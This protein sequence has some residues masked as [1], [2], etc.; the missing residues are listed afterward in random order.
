MKSM[1]KTTIPKDKCLDNTFKL[2]LE[3]YLFIPNRCR[4]YRSDLFQTRMM[5]Q[6]VICMS[7]ESAAKLFY[8]KIR[9]TRKGA[10]PKRIQKTLFGVKAIQTLVGADHKNR[11]SLFVSFMTPS[12]IDHLV[13]IMRKEWQLSSRRWMEKERIV[14]FDEACAMLCR[15][16][17][18]WSG[19][20]LKKSEV[21]QRAMDLS[22]MI[23]AF[24][25]VGPRYWKGKCARKRTEMWMKNMIREVRRGRLTP[26][27]DSI[28]QKIAFHKDRHGKLLEANIAGIEMINILRPITAIATYITFGA[29][30]MEFHPECRV[31]IKEREGNYLHML[32][33]EIRRY[34]PFGPFLGARVRSDFIY[35]NFRFKKG[36]LT[37]LDIYG[38]NH[39][40]RIW[41]KPYRFL[42]EHF[43]FKDGN[44]YD[45]IPQGGGDMETGTRCPGEWIT[46]ELLKD[47]MDFLANNLE[48]RVPLQDLNYSLRRM[49]TLP[50]SRF[51]MENIVRKD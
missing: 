48:Y 23:D 13:A 8:D 31:K 30:A 39:D 4:K 42:P 47:S 25:A 11:K 34:F 33:Q 43:K 21:K 5:G 29:L 46:M 18:R 17:C 14:L 28:L 51:I 15:A 27:H 7:G 16:A 37:F 41:K 49:P 50:K 40:S 45:F 12:R 20:P 32:A 38:T 2:I 36:T 10:I 35:H 6:K 24:G 9:F 26:P 22:A 3:G 19:V 44:P 1:K